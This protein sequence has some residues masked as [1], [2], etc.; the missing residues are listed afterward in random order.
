MIESLDLSGALFH[1]LQPGIAGP[2]FP[3]SQRKIEPFRLE[4]HR[5]GENK[6]GQ[7]WKPQRTGHAGSPGKKIGPVERVK[8][9][10]APQRVS[11]DAAP[12]R[13]SGDFRFGPGHNFLGEQPEIFVRASG[14]GLASG[15]D[16]GAFPWGHIAAPV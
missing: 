3:V 1:R 7:S 12:E 2:A 15:N 9:E 14:A 10:K 16:R 11:G 4:L 6:F 13:E 8:G 5:M